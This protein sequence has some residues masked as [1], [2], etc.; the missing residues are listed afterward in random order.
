MR[1]FSRHFATLLLF[2]AAPAWASDLDV[3]LRGL[4]VETANN[5]APNERFRLLTSELAFALAPRPT[6]PAKTL[7][8]SGFEATFDTTLV[9]FHTGQSY[10]R[11][12]VFDP[13]IGGNTDPVTEKAQLG[14]GQPGSLQTVIG[15]HIRKGLPFS[16]ELDADFN[17]L[18]NSSMVMIGASVRYALVEGFRYA[19]DISVRGAVGRLMG[20]NDIDMITAEASATVGKTFGIAGVCTLGIY[21]GYGILFANVN[22]NV[23]DKTPANAADNQAVQRVGSLYTFD[24]L[25]IGSDYNH[26]VFGGLRFQT[27]IITLYYEFDAGIIT[28]SSL[29]IPT[30][31]FRIGFDY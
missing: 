21:A 16:V 8:M 27:Y 6:A 28:H 26:R 5:T 11:G 13:N 3:S 29:W 30:N 2:S 7:G 22:S 10:W 4:G 14:K 23:I 1:S 24:Q 15:G 31:S 12:G 17:Y 25:S 9:N 19:P 18:V 20:A